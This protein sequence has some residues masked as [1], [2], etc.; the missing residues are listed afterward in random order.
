MTAAVLAH[1]DPA[2]LDPDLSFKDLGIDSLSALELRNTLTRDTG[3]TLPATLVFDH[4]TP[5]TV[6]EHL[7]DLLSGATSPTL[8][9]AP[10]QVDLDAPVAVVG[11]A[12][13]LPGGIESAAGLW[14]V[15]SNGIDVMSGFPTDRGWDVAGL[16]DPDPDAVGKTYTRYGGFVADVA[17]FDAEFFSGSPREKQSRW[18]LNSG[19]CWK[20][21]GKRWNTRAS[22]RPPWKARTPECSSGS[23]RRAT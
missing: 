2:M 18:I 12:C 15:V 8:A 13:R 3:L 6:A 11:M 4:P 14:D 23:G 7:L 9:V 22:T 17:G 21:V 20:C 1:P 16:F 19:C 10:T 5:T